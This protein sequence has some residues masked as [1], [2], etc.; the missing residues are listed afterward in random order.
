MDWQAAFN[1][2]FMAFMTACGWVLK[3]VHEAV[4]T[5]TQDLKALE[6]EVPEKYARKDDMHLI[7]GEIKGALIR[8]EEKLEGKANR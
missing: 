1:L 5:L 4:H 3:S 2:L 6:K 7:L 8:I